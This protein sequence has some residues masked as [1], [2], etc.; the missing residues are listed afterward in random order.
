MEKGRSEFEKLLDKNPRK[1]LIWNLYIDMEIKYGK[2]LAKTR[3][4]FNRVVSL[5]H[6]RIV[7]LGFFKK[8][9]N[10]EVS[11]GDKKTQNH[12]KELAW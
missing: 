5:P 8:F 1:N 11:F 9:L 6:K 4:I 7:A 10:F 3:E 12:V 2:D